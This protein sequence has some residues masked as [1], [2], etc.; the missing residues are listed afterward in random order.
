MTTQTMTPAPG[1]PP[2]SHRSQIKR[3]PTCCVRSLLHWAG[4]GVLVVG[5]MAPMSRSAGG[6]SP[7]GGGRSRARAASVGGRLASGVAALRRGNAAELASL[8]LDLDELRALDDPLQQAQRLMEAAMAGAPQTIEDDELRTAAGRTAIWALED[9]ERSPE[10]EDVIRHFVTEYVYE[11]ILTEIGVVLR[12]GDRDGTAAI[13]AEARIHETIVALAHTVAIQTN[14]LGH[15]DLTAITN[16]V[17][18]DT[19]SVIGSRA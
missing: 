12:S 11:V 18:E 10:V 8:G 1:S 17:L 4:G 15:A 16:G 19:R 2:A 5:V 3:L 14:R 9:G 6:G 13:P 7:G